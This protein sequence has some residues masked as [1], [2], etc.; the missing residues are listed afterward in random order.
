ML[1]ALFV[2]MLLGLTAGVDNVSAWGEQGHRIVC[3]IALELLNAWCE[4]TTD[5]DTEGAPSR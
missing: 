1:W 4:L 5:G 2:V 3:R